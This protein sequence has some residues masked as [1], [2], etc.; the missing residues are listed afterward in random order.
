M[1][2]CKNF[3]LKLAWRHNLIYPIQLL[4]WTLLRKIDT[5]ILSRVFNISTSILFTLLMFLGEFLAGS[6]LYKYQESFVKKKPDK[7]KEKNKFIF[8]ENEMNKKDSNFKIYFL[9][10]ISAFFDFIEFHISINFVPNF[11]QTSSSLELR[12]GG[13]L[14]IISALF[15]YYLLKFPIYKHQLFSLIVIGICLIIVIITEFYFQKTSIFLSY[16]DFCRKLLL[17][18]FVHLFNSL[19]DSIQKYIMEYD[20]V[21]YFKIL[22]IEGFC[23]SLI[24]IIYSFL[25]NSY[26]KIFS[27]IYFKNSNNQIA[28]IIILLF[29][30]LILCGGR[31]A[32]RVVTNKLYSPMTKTLTDYFINPVYLIINYTDDD[33]YSDG[34]KN[35]YYF[36]INFILSIII[37]L[38][39]SVY[40]EIVILLFYNLEKETHEQIARRASINYLEDSFEEEAPTNEENI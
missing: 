9:I 7:E 38:C 28:I 3:E 25:D 22:A 40:N 13:I 12:L 32:F 20:F 6:I 31:N 21:N 1:N 27:K 37:S 33:F 23:G 10:F 8:K 35:I 14:T 39:G 24:T 4:I 11:V 17:I 30:Y 36:L 34:R 15:F 16:Y 19:L 26:K 2:R 5:I 29:I 18:F